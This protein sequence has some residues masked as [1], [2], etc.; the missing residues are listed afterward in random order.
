[1]A[2]EK[3]QHKLKLLPY[4]TALIKRQE[5]WQPAYVIEQD[6]DG[7]YV[8]FLPNTPDT[9]TGLVLLAERDQV[10]IVPSVTANQLDISLKQMGK[11]LLSEFRR[12][13]R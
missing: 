5:Y 2:E 11:G 7:S 4:T 12:D 6:L 8:V 1:M 3:L 9:H 13:K 10:R